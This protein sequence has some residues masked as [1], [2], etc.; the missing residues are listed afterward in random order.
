M[1]MP[2]NFKHKDCGGSIHSRP[3][4]ESIIRSMD[5]W[6]GETIFKCV[7]C[8]ETVK[9]DEVYEAETKHSLYHSKN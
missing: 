9:K 2:E 3:D 5:V 1:K 6:M 8:G 7:K 4:I